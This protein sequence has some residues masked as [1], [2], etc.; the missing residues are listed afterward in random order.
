MESIDFLPADFNPLLK[1]FVYAL[2]LLHILAFAF[3]CF[4]ACPGIFK[5]T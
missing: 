5:K 3:W 4:V 1:I 2:I